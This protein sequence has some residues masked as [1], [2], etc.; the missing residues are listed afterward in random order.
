ML[1]DLQ[2]DKIQEI[3]KRSSSRNSLKCEVWSSLCRNHLIHFLNGQ[4]LCI[5]LMQEIGDNFTY[6]GVK[7]LFLCPFLKKLS[8]SV[9]G[10]VKYWW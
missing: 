7:S 3:K 5:T 2:S 10:D 9:V 1:T 4:I 6:S 8:Y